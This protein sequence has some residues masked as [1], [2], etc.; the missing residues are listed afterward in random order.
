MSIPFSLLILSIVRTGLLNVSFL[1]GLMEIK[2]WLKD[3]FSTMPYFLIQ[4]I[5]S[6]PP[7]LGAF[8][9]FPNSSTETS[10]SFVADWNSISQDQKEFARTLEKISLRKICRPEVLPK[11]LPGKKKTSNSSALFVKSSLLRDILLTNAESEAIKFAVMKPK[12][13]PWQ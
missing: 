2:T 8:F 9:L 5:P 4:T 6:F 10:Q 1:Q 12:S 3:S 7:E 13:N 11:A